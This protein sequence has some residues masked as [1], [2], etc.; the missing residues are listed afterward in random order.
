MANLSDD[1]LKDLELLEAALDLP[2]LPVLHTLQLPKAYLKTYQLADKDK[3]LCFSFAD[4]SY[5]SLTD[6]HEQDCCEYVYA[7]WAYTKP[8]L[9]QDF[10]VKVW[11]KLEVLGLAE[12]GFLLK[13]SDDR[14]ST[15]SFTV[16][17][18]NDQN[19]YYSDNLALKI[20][21]DDANTEVD[22]QNYKKD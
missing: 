11:S 6:Y 18:Y 2:S 14:A 15:M 19:G 5:I 7:D 16:P 17:C 10:E 9:E 3:G 1:L 22:L 13:F 12:L 4:G 20:K 8:F 21:T